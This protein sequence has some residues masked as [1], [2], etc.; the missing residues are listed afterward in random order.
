MQTTG[1]FW[2]VCLGISVTLSACSDSGPSLPDAPSTVHESAHPA[3]Q[4]SPPP[5]DVPPI[6]VAEVQTVT[7]VQDSSGLF[8]S[9]TPE[10]NVPSFVEQSGAPSAS[11][12]EAEE[13]AKIDL[14][15]LFRAHEAG[16]LA[17]SVQ[18]RLLPRDAAS[19]SPIQHYFPRIEAASDGVR[20][21]LRVSS[22]DAADL[23][24]AVSTEWRGWEGF[25]G[26]GVAGS[27]A[28]GATRAPVATLDF[29]IRGRQS[30]LVLTLENG[31]LIITNRS[32]QTI[33][34][35]LLIY[36]HP[37]GVGVT[38]VTQLGPGERRVTVLGPKE[39][40]SDVLLEMARVELA[41]FFALKVGPELGAAMAEAK[42]I[43]FL[44]T[45]GMRLITLLGDE[46]DALSVA[47]A[48]PV[49]QTRV[50]VS[51]SEILKPEEEARVLSVVAD[52]S[53]GAVQAT[54]VLGRFTEAKLEFAELKGDAVV[55]ERS[56]ALLSELRSR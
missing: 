17:A 2:A 40:P 52:P 49:S 8:L 39:Q 16:P 51:H 36:S 5:V 48:S 24:A 35:A 9:P 33:E 11:Q 45:Q 53:V 54:A 15:L 20:W 34:R 12:A 32:D 41:A 26:L 55:R 6:D 29:E 38:T 19:W 43:P 31:T 14:A 23:D 44:E 1:V 3:V 4:P 13:R 22:S 47:F 21:P 56:S 50:I 18:A 30:P 46:Q 7:T 27:A 10:Q 37:G 28:Q 42:S 25:H